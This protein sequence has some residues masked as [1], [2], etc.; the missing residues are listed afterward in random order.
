MFYQKYYF[1]I[2]HKKTEKANI[3]CDSGCMYSSNHAMITAVTDEQERGTDM[4]DTIEAN[5][6]NRKHNRLQ[7]TGQGRSRW[8]HLPYR[9]LTY[10]LKQMYGRKLYKLPIDGGFTCPNRDGTAGYGGCTFCSQNGSGEQTSS[11]TL[12]VTGQIEE[13]KQRLAHKKNIGGYIAYFQAF[14]NTHA[15][16][17]RLRE[18]FL[19]ACADPDIRI[20]S[21]ATRPDCLPEPVIQLL[22]EIN[23][24]IPV[25]VELGL[26]TAHDD[27]ARSFHRG[28]DRDVF[29]DAVKRLRR[30][31]LYVIVHTILYLPGETMHHMRETIRFLNGQDIQG[32]KLS[33]LHIIKGT[34][35]YDEFRRK[36]F[37]LPDMHEYADCLARLISI[38]REDI[39]IH[40]LTGDG[41][42]ALLASPLWTLRKRTV[43]NYIHAYFKQHNIWQGKEYNG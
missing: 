5:T 14:T 36:P 40:R 19:E 9:H 4:T 8:D 37:H 16:L 27:T 2:I 42:A 17:E 22:S 28:Y 6:V 1:Y 31:N 41:P 13:Q 3:F 18:L 30:H 15:P 26:Q 38:M 39:T 21:I 34:A 12:S 24:T 7:S 35:M 29:E 43:L 32:I 23:T 25:W 10:E 20:L 11:R 33:L